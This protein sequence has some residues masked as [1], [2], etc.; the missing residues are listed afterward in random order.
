MHRLAC[1]RV[2]HTERILKRAACKALNTLRDTCA[3][4]ILYLQE[5]QSAS[6]QWRN[7]KTTSMWDGWTEKVDKLPV[8]IMAISGYK[9]HPRFKAI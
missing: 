6:S 9:Y 3:D 7:G 4:S 1:A 2:G 5:L 8:E